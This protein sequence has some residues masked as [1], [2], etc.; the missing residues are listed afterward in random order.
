MSAM[1][2]STMS[3]SSSANRVLQ[4]SS[5]TCLAQSITATHDF[6]VVNFSLLEGMG[7]GVPVRS[8]TF[9][10]GDCDWAIKLY[11]DGEL[12]GTTFLSVQL[13][14][15]QGPAPTRTKFSLSL[16][17]KDGDQPPPPSPS[18]SPPSKKGRKKKKKRGQEKLLASE[19]A[20]ITF[21]SVGSYWGWPL[22]MERSQLREHLLAAAGDRF[23]VRCVVSVFK[24]R[25]VEAGAAVEVPPSDL[26][27]DLAAM[28]RR[29]EG[30][31]VTINVGGRF[32]PAHKHV[33]A[34]RS[35]VFRAQLFGVMR[36]SA[37]Q[38]IDID[39]MDASVFEGLLHFIYTDSLPEEDDDDRDKI[40]VMQHLLVAADRYG[41]SRLRLMCEAKLC[42]WID[43]QSVASTLALAEQHQCV[44][45]KDACLRFIAW[46]DV[47]GP[48]METEGFKHLTASCP[49]VM[50]EILESIASAKIE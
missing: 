50:K 30:A 29:G 41:M 25:V 36:E 32:F 28:L 48:V 12:A 3:S 35:R 37:A 34:A 14:L 23:T 6:T 16:L 13:W 22:F 17:V 49:M 5:S 2:G 24:S 46:R 10:A 9:S 44:Q 42:G 8:S 43:V 45:L 18:P 38:C 19:S 31:D 7:L 39:D 33:L 20:S 15:V 27:R 21:K 1:A 47:L 40:V 11:P 4:P 26:H